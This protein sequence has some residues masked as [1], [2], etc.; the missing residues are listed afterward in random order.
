MIALLTGTVARME[1]N[2]AIV[3][4]AGVGYQVFLPAPLLAVLQAGGRTTLHTHLIVREDELSL[5]GF[6]DPHQVQAFR[7]LMGV[8]GVGPKVALALLS[9]LALHELATALSISD[10]R[11][12]TRVPGVGPKLAQRLC[13]ELGDRMAEFALEQ[14]AEGGAHGERTA[15]ENAAFEDAIEGLVGLG[16]SRA[17]ARKAIQRAYA[18]S[19]LRS[20][21]G[22]L[23]NAGLKLLTGR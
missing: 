13:L 11:L 6:A 21:T 19:A 23:I 1:A 20:N 12:M 7:M 14:R 18:D 8:S 3:D 22:A 5:Y 17:D 2:S 10:T 15:E 4:V 9:T 16:Y